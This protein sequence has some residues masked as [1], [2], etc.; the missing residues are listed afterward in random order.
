MTA[1]TIAEF[2]R[3]RLNEAEQA[4]R[5][6]GAD[7]WAHGGGRTVSW[8]RGSAHGFVAFVDIVPAGEHI[9]RHDPARVLRDIETKRRIIAEHVPW[10]ER[11]HL[12]GIWAEPDP[13]C[14]VCVSMVM[15]EDAGGNR[16]RDLRHE[17]WPCPTLRLLALPHAEH[18]DYQPE[19]RP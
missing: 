16:F 9:A 17:A 6:A 10:P 5:E 7:A 11:G 15:D 19:W 14:S 12:T 1:L 8:Q 2:L 4:A 18:P 3:A 13:M